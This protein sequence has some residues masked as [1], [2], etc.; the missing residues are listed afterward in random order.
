MRTLLISRKFMK[1]INVQTLKVNEE[2]FFWAW[3]KILQPFLKLR[4]QEVQVLSKLLYYRYRIMN[5][6]NIT[7]EV[8]VNELLFGT[9]Y[10]KKIRADLKLEDYS[11]NNILTSLRKKDIIVNNEISNKVIPR[12]DNNFKNFKLIYNFEIIQK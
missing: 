3:L 6:N 5:V 1:N 4:K 12:V 2:N 8:I 7:N 9:Q 11:F 10:R